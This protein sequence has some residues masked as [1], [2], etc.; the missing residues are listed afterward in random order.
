M[1]TLLH[2]LW[3]ESD[4]EQT[5]CLAGPMGADARAR[6]LPGA[7]KVWTVLAESHFDAM[8]KYYGHMAWGVYTTEFASDHDA[9]PEEWLQVQQSVAD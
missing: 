4:Q 9:Y 5:F 1:A 8:T 7:K 3:I 2:E 6:L